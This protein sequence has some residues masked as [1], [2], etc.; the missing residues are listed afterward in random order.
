MFHMFGANN[1]LLDAIKRPA[2]SREYG[3][4]ARATR[5]KVETKQQLQTVRTWLQHIQSLLS[6]FTPLR[7][8]APLVPEPLLNVVKQN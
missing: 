3:D 7:S 8:L 6:T 5:E 2:D 1:F 4:E